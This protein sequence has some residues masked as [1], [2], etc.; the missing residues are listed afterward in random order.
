MNC[1]KPQ[2]GLWVE[3]VIH[4]QIKAK[5]ENKMRTGR[6][7]NNRQRGGR[8]KSIPLPVRGLPALLFARKSR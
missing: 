5:K 4:W 7:Q 8:I 6:A 2:N 3:T 1:P